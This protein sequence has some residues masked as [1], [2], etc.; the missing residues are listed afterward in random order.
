MEL[1]KRA[2]ALI[3][4]GT[5]LL[6]KR[7][8]MYAPEQWPMY[9]KCAKGCRVWTTDN[10]C[11]LDFSTMGI[12]ACL[13]GYANPYVDSA[14]RESIS[15][16]SMCTLNA[17][18]EVDLAELLVHLH[19]WAEMV[20]YARTGGEALAVAVRIA[21]AFT[22]LDTVLFC[23]YHGWHDWY[24][25]AN[26]SDDHA[27]D[28][29]LLPGLLPLGVPR[30]LTGTAIPFAYNDINNFIELFNE[31]LGH[32]G[33]VIMEPLRNS[34]IDKE[35]LHTIRSMTRNANIPLIFDEVTAGWRFALGGAHL[36]Y[37]YVPDM[38]IFAKA[39]SNGYPMAAIIGTK[40]VMQT[41][42]DTFISSTYWTERIG[43]VASIATIEQMMMIEHFIGT[44]EMLGTSVQHIWKS[45]AHE[46]NIDISINQ[47]PQL[48]HFEFETP[49]ALAYKTVFTQY[50]LERGFLASMSY[51]PSIVHNNTNLRKFEEAV[52]ESFALMGKYGTSEL[53]GPVCHAGLTHIN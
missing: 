30:G 26:L 2:H 42:Q 41:A 21:R 13:L 38:A 25:A 14:V 4:G 19:P 18:E 35:F 45:A 47:V 15:D 36:N 24:L 53:K 22:G 17:P 1:V 44:L 28:G 5:Q 20:R 32:I 10:R 12:G 50:M 37:D 46:N 48:A 43:P 16:G 27:L 34:P 40:E 3:P 39:M 11:Y 23:G 49:N 52:R 29:Q 51:Y 33:A 9:Y 6:S 7:P 31:H 8:E